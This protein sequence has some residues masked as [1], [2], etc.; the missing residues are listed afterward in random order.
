MR[1]PRCSFEGSL[2]NGQCP[3]CG[4][5]IMPGT[6]AQLYS[7]P[8]RSVPL[9][10]TPYQT[11]ARPTSLAEPIGLYPLAR[12]DMLSQRRYRILGQITLPQTQQRQGTAWMAV[13]TQV[14]NR[15][16]VIRQI[17]ASPEIAKTATHEQLV[18]NVAQRLQEAGLHEGFPEVVDLFSDRKSFFIVMLYPEGESLATLLKLQGGALPEP[19]VAKIGYEIC[20]LLTIMAQQQPPMVHGSINPDTI[21]VSEDNQRI[22][23]IHLPLFTPD[24]PRGASENGSAGYYAPEQV[25]GEIDP[26]VDLYGLAAT[27]H[28]AVTG[29][30]PRTRLTFFHTPARRLNP[31]VSRQMEMIL[32][33]QL[34]LSKSQRYSHPAEMQQDLLAL[35]A[36][37]PEQPAN[38]P[39]PP[40]ATPVL[41]NPAHIR[42][43]VRDTTMLNMGVFAAISVLL[44]VAFLLVILRP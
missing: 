15:Q 12:G 26:S 19:M 18:S 44:I 24:V 6:S 33:R 10:E 41:L 3:N 29:Y 39:A 36:S 4:Y 13:D 37:Y 16:V 1:C 42:E 23:L 7:T 21:L 5:A 11:L 34:S 14:G 32:A 22:S 8:T 28:H 2:A 25:R 31:A 35:L 30:D 17:V 43:Q 38:N 20:G 40:V 27:L 9:S